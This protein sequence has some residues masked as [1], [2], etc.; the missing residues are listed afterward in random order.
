APSAAPLDTMRAVVRESMKDGAF[1]IS[2]ALIYPPGSYAGTPELIEMAKAMSPYHGGY[3]T[4]MRSEDDSLFEAM[5]EAFRI[6]REGGVRLDIYHL[7]ASNRR[8]WPKAT[9]MV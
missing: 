2:S 3:I 6:A 5:D 8:N 7:K 9:A 4:H 1:G